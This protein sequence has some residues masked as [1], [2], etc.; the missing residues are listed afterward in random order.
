MDSDPYRA[1]LIV[2]F[3][4]TG[5]STT[6]GPDAMCQTLILN[7]INDFCLWG[8]PGS[9]SSSNTSALETVGDVEA[10]MVAFCS[11]AGHGSRIIPAGAIQ[12]VQ[13]MRT[14]QYVQIVGFVDQTAL[15]L[16]ADDTGGE[17]G[18]CRRWRVSGPARVLTCSHYDL[19][20]CRSSWC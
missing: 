12:G 19:C 20:A 9:G 1:P 16:Q 6:E 14:S 10:A 17:E 7:S 11:S 3:F 5:N 15:G 4:N 18:E 2:R 8:A 13:F